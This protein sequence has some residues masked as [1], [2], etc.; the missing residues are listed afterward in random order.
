MQMKRKKNENR[1]GLQK[2]DKRKS[3]DFSKGSA[4]GKASRKNERNT[5]SEFEIS[6][7][8]VF[9]KNPSAV[10]NPKQIASRL[11]KS[12]AKDPESQRIQQ[13]L[14]ALCRQELLQQPETGRY[15]AAPQSHYVVGTMDFTSSGAA[16]LVPQDKEKYADDIYIPATA[17][18]RSL[19]GDT[20]RVYVF[21][22]KDGRRPEGEV[23]E[24]IARA[25]SQFVGRL[26]LSDHFGFVVPDNN[27]IA[28]NFYIPK[29]GLG[30]AHQGDKVVVEIA[31]W[32]DKAPNPV[33]RI[34]EVL[35]RPGE[36]E[37]EIHSI[38]AE[39]GLPYRF[40]DEIETE[41]A[42][43]PIEITEEEIARRRDMREATTFTID[44]ADAKDF[45]DA[46]SLERL[47]NGNY[48]IGVHIADVSHYVKEGTALNDEAFER[49][50]SVY[51][52]DRVVPMLP[53]ILSNNV[54][55]LRPDE[56]KL[57]F[58]AVFEMDEQAHVKNEWFGRTVIRSDRRFAYEQAQAV[59]EGA[60]D[61]L[62]EEILILDG[63]AKKM[64]ER[65][66]AAGAISFDREEVKFTLDADN[67]PTGVFFK[68]SKDANKLIEEFMLLANRRVAAFVGSELRKDPVYKGIAPTFVYRVHD[69]PNPKKLAALSGM[70]RKFGYKVATKDRSSIARSLNR[71]LADVH[72]RREENM[73]ST[74]AMRSMAKAEYSTDN[75]GHYGLAFDYYTHFTSPIRRYPDVMVHR[76]LQHYLERGKSADKE[77]Y[78]EQ[79]RH[80]SA[81]E[82]VAADAERDSVKYMQVKYMAKFVDQEFKGFISGVTEW[83]IYVEIAENKCEGMVRL[84]DIRD[85]YYSFDAQNFCVVGEN[86]HNVLQLGDP[87]IVRVKNADLDRKQLDFEFIRVADE[88]ND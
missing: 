65:R 31:E 72:G 22:R 15:K 39:Y 8:G 87:V 34:L 40:P 67:E 76:L 84:R 27:R 26:E 56:E 23:V 17:T 13:A 66:M 36:H 50:T 38:L 81:R 4:R 9:H 63:M 57:T 20:V 48:R 6:V 82:R 45:D 61:P 43:L 74:L 83:G 69:D 5:L 80:S 62:R 7:L 35:G 25:K 29:E 85:D 78:E 79:C 14:D 71:M 75:I 53:E 54:C 41:A 30:D 47:E 64:R 11:V 10:Y 77:Q 37:V 1:R 32:P 55:S 49:G 21:R 58:S 46:L 19:H 51:L 59:I 33:G 44:P 16:Y 12:G 24:I 42:A 70:A 73:L 60:D 18:A 52:V 86:S 28:V 2:A 68:I 88:E 3:K